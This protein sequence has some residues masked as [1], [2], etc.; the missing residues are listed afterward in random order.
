MASATP[1]CFGDIRCRFA[2]FLPDKVKFETVLK[3]HGK[4]GDGDG[5][6]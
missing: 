2:A 3:E 4:M 6:V 1:G 5:Y